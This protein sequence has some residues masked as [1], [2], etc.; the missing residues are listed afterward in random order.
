MAD[1]VMLDTSV[2]VH[3]TFSDLPH[4]RAVWAQ[5]DRARGGGPGFAVSCHSLAELAWIASDG[6]LVVAPDE[7]GTVRRKLEEFLGAR[8]L[9]KLEVTPR[10]LRL[11]AGLIGR[12][13]LAGP[14]TL[15]ALIVASM[16]ENGIDMLHT[17]NPDD[18]HVFPDIHAA[19]PYV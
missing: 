10:T 9:R 13:A 1:M 15:D 2:L 11:Q 4:H 7:P 16:I 14:R 3:A 12:H 19:C 17:L 18:F 5:L 6:R 8:F